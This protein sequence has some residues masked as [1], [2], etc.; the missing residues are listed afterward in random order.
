[1]CFAYHSQNS[2]TLRNIKFEIFFGNCNR[3]IIIR[4]NKEPF[5]LFCLSLRGAYLWHLKRKGQLHLLIT[6]I[7]PFFIQSSNN[8]KYYYENYLLTTLRFFQIY[9]LNPLFVEINL[10]K[11]DILVSFSQ[12]PALLYWSS[13]NCGHSRLR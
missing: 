9:V 6:L 5:F 8:H 4:Q 11:T 2:V 13:I 1:M 3:I 10:L 12:I 7:N